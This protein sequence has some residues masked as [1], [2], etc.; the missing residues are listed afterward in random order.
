M[1]VRVS[2][3]F[4][5]LFSLSLSVSAHR[6]L[7]SVLAPLLS[8]RR[9]EAHSPTVKPWRGAL[10]AEDELSLAR[11]L[12]LSPAYLLF[13]SPSRQARGQPS[14]QGGGGVPSILVYFFSSRARLRDL[15]LRRGRGRGRGRGREGGG[16][17]RSRRRFLLQPERDLGSACQCF[18]SFPF[19]RRERAPVTSWTPLSTAIFTVRAFR[20]RPAHP[21]PFHPLHHHPVRAG[22]GGASGSALFVRARA[23][24]IYV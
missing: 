9:I 4:P 11:N 10:H 15:P 17:A 16:G 1:R 8:R 21:D 18:F 20:V 12:T 22:A 13:C 24:G 23:A 19:F 6:C 14:R 5:S 2:C 7:R 3:L